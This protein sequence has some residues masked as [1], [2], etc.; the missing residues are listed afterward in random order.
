MATARDYDSLVRS[1]IDPTMTD[2]VFNATPLLKRFK[3][4][5]KVRELSDWHNLPLETAE[6]L[7]GPMHD[8][9]TID[10]SR[11]EISR[12]S[13]WQMKE[14]YSPLTVSKRDR[15]ICK[16][17]E[18]VVDL[19]QAK[20]R[21][22]QKTLAKHLTDGIVSDGTTN[23]KHFVGLKRAIPDSASADTSAYGGITAST[24]SFWACQNQNKSS[25]TVTYV[26][27]VN[28]IT[29]CTD[30]IDKTTIIATDKFIQAYIW[31]VLLQPQERYN[32]GKINTAS[33]L[34]EVAG[35]GIITDAAFESSGATGGRMYFLNE[36]NLKLW[37]H[38]RD[39]MKYWPF[40]LADDQFAWT[41]KWTLSG[42]LGCDKRKNQGIIYGITTS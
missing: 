15:M 33:G 30:G 41:A 8:L 28:M 9:D 40:M 3:A 27:I 5:A 29:K 11:K 7:G 14:Y 42:F 19:L 10:R 2:N 24:D 21:N 31:A 35:V 38:K 39:N 34:P 25:T 20:A 26:D 12:Y 13:T 32:D 36:N 1:Y 37:I 6:G 4:K 18:D 22:S 17:P 23:T 16:G